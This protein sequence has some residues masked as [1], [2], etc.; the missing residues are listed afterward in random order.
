MEAQRDSDSIETQEWLDLLAAVL[1]D[2]VLILAHSPRSLK[3]LK[4]EPGNLVDRNYGASC[5]LC[6]HRHSR[7]LHA[8]LASGK[9]ETV[10]PSH[11]SSATNSSVPRGGRFTFALGKAH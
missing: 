8:L 1:A 5:A 2:R 3:G 10:S 6:R 11:R 4:V 7:E 9:G